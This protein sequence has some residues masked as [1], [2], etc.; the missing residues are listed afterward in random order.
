MLIPKLFF[1]LIVDP[2][3]SLPEILTAPKSEGSPL[4]VKILKNWPKAQKKP[5][6]ALNATQNTPAL[7]KKGSK[8]K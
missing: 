7:Y 4:M 2:V 8:K 3:F 6:D 5:P 1:F